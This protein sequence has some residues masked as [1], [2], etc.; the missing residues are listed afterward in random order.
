MPKRQKAQS[1]ENNAI[2]YNPDSR[3]VIQSVMSVN[4]LLTKSEGSSEP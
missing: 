2:S 1:V 4:E 3:T